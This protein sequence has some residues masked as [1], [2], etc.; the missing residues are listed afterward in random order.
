VFD[1]TYIKNVN[2]KI[3][4]AAVFTAIKQD[5]NNRH[6]WLFAVCRNFRQIGREK[7]RRNEKL[8]CAFHLC[9][10]SKM[11][12]Y[13]QKIIRIFFPML[14]VS[15]FSNNLIIVIVIF[16]FIIVAVIVVL[17]SRVFHFLFCLFFASYTN[18]R[19]TPHL[20]CYKPITH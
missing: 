17:S 4:C 1:V 20:H 11:F 10:L 7:T 3:L 16:I 9:C 14:S 6:V 19:T 13:K 18:H 2:V 15:T 12:L 8:L 5:I